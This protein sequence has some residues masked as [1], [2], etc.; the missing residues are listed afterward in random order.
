MTDTIRA[1]YVDDELGL[2]EIAKFY[3]EESGEFSVTTIDSVSAALDLLG[4]EK[5]DVIISDYQMPGMDGI[6]FLVEVRTRFGKIPFILFTGK[7]REEVV[8]QAI[9]SG[10]DFYLQKGGEPESQFAELSHKIKAATSRNRAEDVIKDAKEYSEKLIQTAN[11]MIIGLNN[12]GEIITFNPAAE[13]ITGYTSAD[14]IGCNWFEVIVPKERYPHVW[15][16]FNR[17][18]IGGLPKHF[19]NHILTKSGEERYIVWKNSEICDKGE[20]VGIIAFGIDI[21]ERKQAEQEM[22][23]AFKRLKEAQHLA[24]IGIWDWVIETDTVTWSEELYNIVGRDPSLPAPTYAEL[25]RFYTPASWESLSG[26]V[27][28][29]LTTSEPYNLEL[30]MIRPDGNIRWTNEF[31]GVQSDWSGKVIGLHGTVQDI[32]KLKRTEEALQKSDERLRFISDNLTSGVVIVDVETHTIE[33][34]NPAAS[35]LFM[36]PSDHI[37]GKKCHNFLCPADEGAC[38]ITDLNQEV[39]NAE[40]V[41]LQMDGSTIPILKSVKRIQIRSREKLLENFIDITER[42]RM[43]EALRE[44]EGKRNAML[45][46][47]AD[48]MSMMDKNLNIIWANETAKRYF[49]NDLVGR[50]CYE[51]YHQRQN[52]CEPYPCITLKAFQDGK[53]HRHETTVIDINGQ[54]KFFECSANVALN[55]ENGKPIAVLEI[56]RDI[57]ERKQMEDA[58]KKSEEKY[59]LIAENTTDTIWIFDMNLHLTYVSPSVKNMRGFTADETMRQTLN[60]MMTPESVASVIKLFNEE[61][62]LV[63]MG[64]ADPN[65]FVIIETEDYCKDGAIIIVKNSARLLLD[66]NNLPFA[67]LGISHDITERKQAEEALYQ[68]NKKLNLLSGITR[69]DLKNKVLIIQGLLELAQKSKVIYEIEPLLNKI[70]DSTKAIEHQIDFSKDYQDLGIKLPKWMNLSNMVILA[71]N[72]AIHITDETKNLQIFADPLFEKVMYNLADNTI[73]HGETATEVHVSVVNEQENIRIIWQDNGVG[74]PA[75]QKKLIFNRGFGKNTG[76]GLF[77]IREILAITGMTIQENGEPGKGA[78]FEITVPNGKW[79]YEGK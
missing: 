6:E 17:L 42:R 57:T 18:L 38:P 71:S 67:I 51:V 73:R 37:I 64:K 63:A 9:N 11:A 15:K 12:K 8:I 10:A 20:I 70:Q 60:E 77:L 43:E 3:L 26:A 78:R 48:H 76:F 58:I 40:R 79:R 46:S 19:E 14:M 44:S 36:T 13:Q 52:P 22:V 1:L 23:S 45:E 55:E 74:V 72:P 61:M 69:H 66:Q 31:G 53:I 21:T 54:A 28:R 30:E 16:E 34:A 56:S 59:R 7:G 65:R 62:T 47:I 4:K 50:K 32:T 25:P 29:A 5:F 33:F 24:H 27:T 35:T 41:L 49:G 39:D 2:L 68:A 75:D